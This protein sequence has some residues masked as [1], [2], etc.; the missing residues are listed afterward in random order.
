MKSTSPLISVIVPIYN[1]ERF[2]PRCIESIMGQS[3]PN[4]EIIL[5]DDESPDN[6][7]AICDAY[8]EKDDR[9]IVIHQKNAELSGARN[10]GLDI[11]TGEYISF[12]DSDDWME[13]DMLQE[14]LSFA[15]KNGLDV[16]EC[17]S[18]K[19]NEQRDDKNYSSGVIETNE[20]AL[21]RIIKNQ[22][23]AVWRRI[24]HKNLLEDL[25]FI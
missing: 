5:I 11:A 24:I 21:E 14:M 2:L 6:C 9:I 13:P 19:S 23:F 18:I 10:S 15:L 12:V 16:V 7:G 4:L 17:G 20:Q 22:T 25:R 3:Y 8:S 1:V